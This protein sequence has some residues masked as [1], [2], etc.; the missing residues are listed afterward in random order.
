VG[1]G[2]G[3]VVLGTLADARADGVCVAIDV[4]RDNLGEAE[5][6][7]VRVAIQEAL[8][9]EGVLVDRAGGACGSMLTAYSLQLGN[10]VT[11]TLTINGKTVSGNASSLDELDLLVGQL[12]RSL[13]T[14]RS[15]ATGFGVTDRTNV[16]RDQTAPRR[17]PPSA[18]RWD[19][20]FAIGGGMLQL[21]ATDERPRQR[22]YSVVALEAR[23]WGFLDG[24]EQ[25]ALEVYGR[26]L[27]HD[28]NLIRWTT[29]RYD[30]VADGD[31][32]GHLYRG[33]GVLLS[34]FGV[35]NY[36]GGLGAVSFLG[37]SAPRP[38]VRVGATA[39]LLLR[40][41]DPEHRID[42]GFGGYV[43]L[44]LQLSD[45]INLSVAANVSN[46]VV[47]DFMDSGYWYF[48]TTTAMLEVRAKGRAGGPPPSV[49]QDDPVPVIRRINH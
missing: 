23:T 42:L 22:Q 34:P 45:T 9:R 38:F 20:V 17:A 27:L 21:P 7:A 49:L 47:H 43:G 10:R 37:T 39:S 48:L 29:E 26:I 36:E 35:A 14:G 4:G 30:R 18:R 2:V 33:S 25:S 28:Y 46:P 44:G 6:Y 16:L 40:V 32:Q 11:T 24:N 12:V 13:V 19:P 41:T 15:L 8:I 1:V 3:V 31:A 5:R